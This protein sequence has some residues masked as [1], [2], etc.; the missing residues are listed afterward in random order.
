MCV[1]MILR[2]LECKSARLAMVGGESLLGF[3]IWGHALSP[4]AGGSASL[5][6]MSGNLCPSAT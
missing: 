1:L 5:K 6:D 2:K 4:P 3:H